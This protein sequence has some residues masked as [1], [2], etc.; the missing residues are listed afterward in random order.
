[1]LSTTFSPPFNFKLVVD[2][3]VVEGPAVVCAVVWVGAALLLLLVFFD[4][5]RLLFFCTAGNETLLI[6]SK[7]T[8]TLEICLCSWGGWDWSWPCGC[9]CG[10]EWALG[11]SSF[12]VS[13]S[14]GNKFCEASLAMRSPITPRSEVIDDRFDETE[15]VP[16]VDEN[17]ELESQEVTP[18]ATDVLDVFVP[19][20]PSEESSSSLSS[21]GL[22]ANPADALL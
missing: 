3:S 4:D 7:E 14:L 22:L 12:T 19:E 5:D 16:V 11:E 18:E 2:T 13:S 21:F 10:F 17:E 15:A 6:S 1:M 20:E 8:F 9:G